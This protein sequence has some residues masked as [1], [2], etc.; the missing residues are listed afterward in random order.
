MNVER[1][2]ICTSHCCLVGPWGLT[3]CHKGGADRQTEPLKIDMDNSQ[4][5]VIGPTLRAGEV[6]IETQTKLL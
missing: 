3:A 6:M 5:K 4:I 1:H 2:T